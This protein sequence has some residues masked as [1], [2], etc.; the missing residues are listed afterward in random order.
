M[1]HRKLVKM[2]CMDIESIYKSSLIDVKSIKID[3]SLPEEE[4]ILK[5]LEDIKNPYWFMCGKVPVQVSF[6]ENGKD[7]STLLMDFFSHLKTGDLH[8]SEEEYNLERKED[9][10]SCL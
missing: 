1:D 6:R 4:R 2:T 5:Y 10:G 8:N 9:N 7:L 3:T